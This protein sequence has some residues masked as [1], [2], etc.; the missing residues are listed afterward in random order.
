MTVPVR[1]T[2]DHA[3]RRAGVPHSPARVRAAV[4]ALL[5]CATMLAIPRPAGAQD[6][7]TTRP[8]ATADT[9]THALSLGDAARVAGQQSAAALTA[10]AQAQ[11]ASAFTRQKFGSFLPNFFGAGLETER[12]INT[13]SLLRFP[14]LPP[15]SPSFG[16]LFP[17]GGLVLPPIRSI[18]FRGY[19]Y[20]TLFSYTTLQR[21]RQAKTAERAS[22]ST[23]SS[24]A[25]QAA[26]TAALAYLLVQHDVALVAARLADSA[27]AADLLTIA[28]QQL[29]AGVG[30]GLDVTRAQ[31]QLANTRA[32]LISARGARDRSR[33]NLYHALGLPLDTRLVLTDSLDRL[34]TNEQA[35]AESAAVQQALRDRPDL[36]A[37]DQQLQAAQQQVSAV[38]AERT[39]TVEA[40]GDLG[41]NGATWD[42]LLHTYDWGIG[43]TVPAFDGLKRESR[44]QEE[45]AVVRQIAYQR[46]DLRQTAAIQ[47]RGALLDLETASEELKANEEQL[48][49]AQQELDQAQER[50]RTGVASN[51]DVITA[52]QD[53]NAARTREV[54]ALT[55]YQ[56]ARVGLANSIG[57]IMD[58]P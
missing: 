47:V 11:Q 8:G 43:V 28:R 12:T 57:T 55:A 13:A 7:M 29:D 22:Y 5:A 1:A 44:I 42:R 19:G 35:P 53:L 45:Q 50:F 4:A 25:Q 32:Q 30:I 48:H 10:H 9:V 36:R 52:S 27:L 49:F 16:D 15:G 3:P 24:A 34:P 14:T 39:P 56:N 38:G 31:S 33:L 37:I 20:D 26:N 21:Y 51:A 46:R 58:L 18:D 6:G 17:P 40:Y 41:V 23:A 2:G 54:D